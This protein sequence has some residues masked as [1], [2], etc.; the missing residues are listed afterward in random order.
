MSVVPRYVDGWEVQDRYP[1]LDTERWPCAW[2][3][4][5]YRDHNRQS[6]PHSGDWCRGMT[7]SPYEP[8]VDYPSDL[9]CLH[10]GGTGDAPHVGHTFDPDD[11]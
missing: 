1:E 6:G 9:N 10:C 3:G 2:C 7:D 4:E 11:N 8:A 5:P